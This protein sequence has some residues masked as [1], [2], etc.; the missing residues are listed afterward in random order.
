M[1]LCERIARNYI[2]LR[3]YNEKCSDSDATPSTMISTEWEGKLHNVTGFHIWTEDAHWQFSWGQQSGQNYTYASPRPFTARLT[4]PGRALN[5]RDNLLLV[6]ERWN[7]LANKC[8][9]FTTTAPT[10]QPPQHNHKFLSADEV[11]GLWGMENMNAVS[12]SNISINFLIM[13]ENSWLFFYNDCSCLRTYFWLKRLI[14]INL[15]CHLQ[16]HKGSV[17]LLLHNL[18]FTYLVYVI[19][20]IQCEMHWSEML[21]ES[22]ELTEGKSNGTKLNGNKLKEPSPFLDLAPIFNLDGQ[23]ICVWVSSMIW[24]TEKAYRH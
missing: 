18:N 10:P 2:W 12:F 8:L 15:C 21:K 1:V 9:C 14:I 7:N 23:A 16:P 22:W 3:I 4:P 5:N 19:W 13:N 17:D 11:T 20:L 6:T 24:N